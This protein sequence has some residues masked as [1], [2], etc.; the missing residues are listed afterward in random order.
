MSYFRGKVLPNMND[1]KS[2]NF[3]FSR[4]WQP[5]KLHNHFADIL[6]LQIY[7]IFTALAIVTSNGLLL[8]KLFKKRCKTRADKIFIILSCSDV[9]VGLFSIPITPIP[10]FS[11]SAYVYPSL[12]IFSPYFPYG[13]SWI[14]V[15]IIALDRVFIVT[16]G[17][18][19]KQYITMKTLYWII[20][21]CLLFVLVTVI[22]F[23]TRH[24]L[25]KQHS[26]K[27]FY[28]IPLTELSFIFITIVAYIYLFHYVRSKSRMVAK[29]RHGGADLNKKLTL[30]VTCTFL[31]LLLFTLPQFVKLIII[32]S[33]KV[34]D[35]RMEMNLEYWGTILPYSNS[36]ANALVILYNKRQNYERN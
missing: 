11:V 8:H 12:W 17:Q 14:L 9:G 31:C 33:G 13:F 25:F 3:A 36:Y 27:I 30:T 21:F 10:L 19:Y 32:F 22:L 16:K 34:G 29:K 18:S 6:V 20:I 1:T 5:S 24:M 4:K 28:L 26:N 7:F 15:V 35:E 23:I 2:K